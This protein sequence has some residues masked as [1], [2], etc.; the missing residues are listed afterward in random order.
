MKRLWSFVGDEDDPFGPGTDLIISLLA[1]FLV[2]LVITAQ[3]YQ[4]AN[5]KYQQ[6]LA[7]FQI[8]F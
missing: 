2:I 6:G 1:V 5:T 3:S 8:N 7:H 4:A